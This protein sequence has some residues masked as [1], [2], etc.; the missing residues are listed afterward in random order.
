MHVVE[1]E[2]SLPKNNNLDDT[3]GAVETIFNAVSCCRGDVL[4]NRRLEDITK[5][6]SSEKK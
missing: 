3:N 6:H 4:V 5:V 2:I 1:Y